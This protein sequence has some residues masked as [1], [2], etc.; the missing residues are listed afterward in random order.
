MLESLTTPR[1]YRRVSRAIQTVVEE[2][3]YQALAESLRLV[4]IERFGPTGASLGKGYIHPLEPLMIGGDDLMVIVPGDAALPIATRLCQLFER[5]MQEAI[6]EEVWSLLPE[7][8]RHPTLAAGVVIAD[9]HNPVR[10]LQQIS[11]ELCSSAKQ[12]AYDEERRAGVHTS[13]I[14]FLLLK[15]QSML[16]RDVDKLRKV[17]P[18]YFEEAGRKAG[19]HMT[20]A[21]YTLEEARRLLK[22]L[23]LM[24]QEGFATSQL[25]GLVSALQKGRQYG[26]VHYHYQK[27]RLTAREGENVLSLLPEIWS[28]DALEDPVPWHRVSG[29]EGKEFATIVPDLLELYPFVPQTAPD[30]LW[31]EILTEVSNV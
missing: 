4:V 21:P 13:A 27:A 26:T 11:K 3:T 8:L 1:S 20:A 24:R 31:K 15:S 28:Y 25:H 7:A 18:Y 9:S 19:R 6:P 23:K 29:A 30:A 16:R 14:D 2:I 17:R 12:R 22:L 5:K 10:V